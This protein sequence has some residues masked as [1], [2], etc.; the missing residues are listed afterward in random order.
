[1]AQQNQPEVQNG[2]GTQPSYRDSHA[3]AAIDIESRLRTVGA[4]ID[5]YARTRCGGKL[6]D[7]CGRPELA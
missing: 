6:H 2:A 3:A 5:F 7:G 4:I 1:M